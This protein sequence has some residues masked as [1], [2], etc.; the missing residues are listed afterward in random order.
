MLLDQVIGIVAKIMIIISCLLL[1]FMFPNI[2]IH[3]FKEQLLTFYYYLYWIS[4]KYLRQDQ[5]WAK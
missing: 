1:R 4:I 5:Y 2:I 3:L